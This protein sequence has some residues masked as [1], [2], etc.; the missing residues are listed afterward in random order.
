MQRFLRLKNYWPYRW[1]ALVKEK[2]E[3]ERLS[4]D[5][6]IPGS[7][8]RQHHEDVSGS[9]KRRRIG[10]ASNSSGLENVTEE[11]LYL[12]A[13]DSEEVDGMDISGTPNPF[14]VTKGGD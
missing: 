1:R 2:E 9:R 4:E 5:H 12:E 7:R 3:N 14:Q 13:Q 10:D 6:L 8:K 11:H